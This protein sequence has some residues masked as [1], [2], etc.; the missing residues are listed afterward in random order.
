MA[1]QVR[2]VPEGFHTATPY[3]IVRNAAAAL[4]FYVKAFGAT[5]LMRHAAA[6]RRG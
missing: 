5:E 2:P 3:M 1:S 6:A 4:D